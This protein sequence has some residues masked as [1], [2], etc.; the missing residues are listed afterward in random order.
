MKI[1]LKSKLN[2]IYGYTIVVLVGCSFNHDKLPIPHSLGINILSPTSCSYSIFMTNDSLMVVSSNHTY[3]SSKGSFDSV[4]VKMSFLLNDTDKMRIN[5]FTDFLTM[6]SQI[7]EKNE[8]Q[9]LH[10]YEI[11]LNEKLVRRRICCDDTVRSFLKNVI[12]SRINKY[13]VS[14]NQFF[15][16]LG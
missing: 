12:L 15:Y 16:L 3:S 5:H 2:I 4:F 10:V 14:C 6:E 9:D 1:N 13:S 7:I 8:T 11:F